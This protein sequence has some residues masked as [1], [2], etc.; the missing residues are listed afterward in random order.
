M[1]QLKIKDEIWYYRYGMVSIILED[2]DGRRHLKSIAEMG[3][4][5]IEDMNFWFVSEKMIEEYISKFFYT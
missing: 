5:Y 2:P 1:K 4:E 3:G